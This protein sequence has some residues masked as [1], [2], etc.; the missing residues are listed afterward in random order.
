M[1]SSMALLA[2]WI[3]G[4]SDQNQWMIADFHSYYAFCGVR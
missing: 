1:S 4:L 2:E 3:R